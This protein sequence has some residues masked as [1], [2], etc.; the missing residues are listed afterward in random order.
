MD[1]NKNFFGHFGWKEFK[2]N[3]DE[4]LSEFDRSILKNQ[5]RPV[6]VAHGNA[7][8]AYI[9]HWLDNFLPMRYGITSGYIIPDIITNEYELLEYDVIIYDK[10]N[11]PILWIDENFDDSEQGKKRAIPAKYVLGVIEVKSTFNKKSVSDALDKLVEI[12]SLKEHLHVNFFSSMLFFEL[13]NEDL[14]KHNILEPFLKKEPINFDGAIILR[15]KLNKDM[16]GRIEVL[17]IQDTDVK[18]ADRKSL[19]AK[20]IEELKITLTKESNGLN[21]PPGAAVTLTKGHNNLWYVNKTYYGPRLIGKKHVVTLGWS[22]NNFSRF[23][24]DILAQ[25]EGRSAIDSND[26]VYGQ[27]YDIIEKKK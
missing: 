14:K 16:V 20:D 24:I 11:S 18:E 21:V 3:R 5:S 15:S 7:G 23:T 27:V 8:E 2:S 9:R 26:T 17:N 4:I 12:N 13:K 19:L 22:Y 6:K 10:L 1:Q 25:L